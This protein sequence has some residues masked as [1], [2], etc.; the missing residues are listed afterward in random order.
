MLRVIMLEFQMHDAYRQTNKFVMEL[1]T[2]L[3]ITKKEFIKVEGSLRYIV[4]ENGEAT[5]S[6]NEPNDSQK[7]K[8]QDAKKIVEKLTQVGSEIKKFK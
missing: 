2:K 3:N 1:K 6:L 7:I 4:D 5:H 8:Y